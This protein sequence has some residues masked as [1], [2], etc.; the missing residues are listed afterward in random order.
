MNELLISIYPHIKNI[1]YFY[2]SHLYLTS[3]FLQSNNNL[4]LQKG[5]LSWKEV[6]SN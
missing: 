1:I 3:F 2:I 4:R 6:Q 5:K